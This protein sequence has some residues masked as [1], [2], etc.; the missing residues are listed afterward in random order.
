MKVLVF[1]G[2]IYSGF[3]FAQKDSAITVKKMTPLIINPQSSLYNQN[4]FYKNR[5]AQED[6]RHKILIVKP[7]N[8]DRYT[9]LN[10]TPQPYTYYK[11]ALKTQ[12]LRQHYQSHLPKQ[13]KN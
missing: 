1:I 12:A 13:P 10:K 11:N 4:H 3:F 6:N 2:F 5:S 8:P 7:K 9:L